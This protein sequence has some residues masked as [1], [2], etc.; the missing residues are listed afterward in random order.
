VSFTLPNLD[1]RTYADLVAEGLRI[2][3]AIGDE[4][5]NRNP[6]D[7][8]ITLLELFAYTTETLIFRVNQITDDDRRAFARLLCSDAELLS[9]LPPRQALREAARRARQ[10]ERLV[11]CADFEEAALEDGDVARAHCVARRDLTATTSAARAADRPGHVSVLIVPRANA[12]SPVADV[13]T[14]VKARL[15]PRRLVGTIVHVGEPEY[16]RVRVRLSVTLQPGVSAD[17]VKNSLVSALTR[18]FDPLVGGPAETGWPMGRPV[19]VSEMYQLV[20]RTAGVDYATRSFDQAKGTPVD[21]LIAD[22]KDRFVRNANSELVS[23]LLQEHE[24]P[25]ADIDAQSIAVRL[26]GEDNTPRRRSS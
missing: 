23:V 17:A 3:A 22:P 7:P 11:T 2:I 14:R 25:R 16:V 10:R 12:P 21:E 13:L 9:Q 1:D 15:D 4:W 18:F 26:A 6:S 24:L 5:T 8:G 19:H 20:D